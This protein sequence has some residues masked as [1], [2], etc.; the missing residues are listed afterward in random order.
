VCVVLI[1]SVFAA[2]VTTKITTDVKNNEL[3]EMETRAETEAAY[4]SEWVRSEKQYVTTLSTHADF[5][6]PTTTTRVL[7]SEMSNKPTVT[8]M[9]VL[10]GEENPDN[11]PVVTSTTR[12][13]SFNASKLSIN[14][15]EYPNGTPRQF[16]FSSDDD[17]FVSWVYVKNNTKHVA[18]ATP[19]T[20]TDT[21]FV[22]EYNVSD[23]LTQ[24][25]Q[26]DADSDTVVLGGV[27]A[28]VLF[29]DEPYSTTSFHP[30]EGQ[31]NATKIGALI[32]SRDSTQ[33]I[34]TGSEI[35]RGDVRG[36]HSVTEDSVDWVV[37]EEA[38]ASTALALSNTVTIDMMTMTLV[39]LFGFVLMSAVIHFGPIRHISR[40]SDKATVITNGDAD[41]TV[42][43]TARNDEI[44]ELQNAFAEITDQHT[45][46]V[47]QAR[48][49][50]R[51]EFNHDCLDESLP[52]E[53]GDSLHHMHTELQRF[54]T[55]L[56]IERE[57]YASLVKQSLDGI[58]VL[59]NGEFV[60]V[61][62]TF[63][64]MIGYSKSELNNIHP[65]DVFYPYTD[66]FINEDISHI[67]DPDNPTQEL[68]QERVEARS[69][70]GEY[71]TLEISAVQITHNKHPAVLL[72]TRNITD[73]DR[74]EK[75]LQVF[76]RVLRHNLRSD[77]Q[78][79]SGVLDAIET[80]DYTDEQLQ[81]ARMH[82]D[83][84]LG[85]ADMARQ[86]EESLG[87]YGI[88]ETTTT[89]VIEQ[90]QS[91]LT[92][93]YPEKTIV[94]SDTSHCIR[95]ST[96]F[97]EALW[98]VI[99][100]VFE[101]TDCDECKIEITETTTGDKCVDGVCIAV[102]DNGPGISSHEYRP[103]FNGVETNLEHASGLGLWF[104]KWTVELVGGEL[105]ITGTPN[106]TTVELI[107]PQC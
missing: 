47:K 86:I 91:R 18:L 5:T 77:L 92:Q 104:V 103:V 54:F 71:K 41:V 94:H 6:T 26:D 98:Q 78:V 12:T 36:Y 55:E 62:E 8:A 42:S 107:Q 84:L 1:V 49:I 19:I 74:R 44:G 93:T 53:L 23:Q 73:Q 20:D 22:T 16:N 60:L 97:N 33:P 66:T 95:A 87:E 83:K 63:A 81:L 32:E 38:P 68:H 75:Q 7:R 100:N 50:S 51:Q 80:G 31:Q 10:S 79:I 64:D 69:K 82:A 43:E 30:Y 89:E 96:Y 39:T 45:T 27:S 85:S 59:R 58:I 11:M 34:L 67:Q 17:T 28:Y 14:W 21:V 101:H 65:S 52:G 29:T 56:R 35:S 4:L 2:A 13:H 102:I 37:V 40:L 88:E 99:V 105:R 57:N 24:S 90:I 46:V 25:L 3:T 72:T 61:N 9:H 15:G 48:H 106:G 76:N 70:N